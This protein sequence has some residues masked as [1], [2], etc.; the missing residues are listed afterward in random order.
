MTVRV[1]SADSRDLLRRRKHTTL[2]WSCSVVAHGLLLGG[3][4]ALGVRMQPPSSTQP[5]RWDVTLVQS[6]AGDTPVSSQPQ[7]TG[8]PTSQAHRTQAIQSATSPT[9]SQPM[10]MASVAAQEMIQVVAQPD[11]RNIR[12]KTK[13][14]PQKTTTTH[15]SAQPEKP[16]TFTS[17]SVHSNEHSEPGDSS[18]QSLS[19]ETDPPNEQTASHSEQPGTSMTASTLPSSSLLEQ[20]SNEPHYDWLGEILWNR[21]HAFKRYPTSAAANR[22]EGEVLLTAVIEATGVIPDIRIMKSSG[23]PLLDQ[24]AI[25]TVQHASP[26]TLIRPLEHSRVSV[27]IPIT[28]HG[29]T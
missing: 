11:H 6:T 23:H 1:W 4:I 3:M 26:L 13:E 19:A 20:A 27:E 28:Y 15:E 16:Q 12:Q 24:A 18:A 25:E 7:V 22:L 29:H 5:F 21:V 14:S 8:R 10:S 9:P 17:Q 2:G